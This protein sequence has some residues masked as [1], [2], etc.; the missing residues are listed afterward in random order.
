MRAVCATLQ[1]VER[2]NPDYD[3]F[4]LAFFIAWLTVLFILIYLY[5]EK[6]KKNKYDPEGKPNRDDP[7]LVLG[8]FKR[9]RSNR[10]ARRRLRYV[11]TGLLIA[12]AS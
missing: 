11:C 1:L 7:N 10:S 6:R 2:I 9:R 4:T 5:R 8:T 3:T 12:R